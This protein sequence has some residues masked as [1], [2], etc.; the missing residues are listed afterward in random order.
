MELHKFYVYYYCYYIFSVLWRTENAMQQQIT[1][2]RDELSKREQALRSMTGKAILNGI[3][4]IQKVLQYFRDQK[5]YPEVIEGYY[6]TLIENFD[7]E[8]TFF[9]AVEVTAGTR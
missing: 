6:G 1:S 4:S 3:D 7:C 2:L 8:K 9:T 5:K